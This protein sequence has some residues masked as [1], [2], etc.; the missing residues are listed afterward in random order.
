MVVCLQTHDRGSV[1][2]PAIRGKAIGTT[3]PFWVII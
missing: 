1:P 3:L 2:E